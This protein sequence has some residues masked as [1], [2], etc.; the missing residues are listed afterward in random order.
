MRVSNSLCQGLGPRTCLFKK[1]PGDVNG[2]GLGK[3]LVEPLNYSVSKTLIDRNLLGILEQCTS[4][5]WAELAVLH[6]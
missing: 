2:T 5:V 4:E 3:A 6:L 1:P